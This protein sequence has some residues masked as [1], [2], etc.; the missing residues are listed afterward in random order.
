MAT[1]RLETMLG[2][3]AVAVHPEDPR[4]QHLLGRR[5]QH[6]FASRTIPIIADNVRE[7]ERREG[8]RGRGGRGGEGGG[9]V[10][11][12]IYNCFSV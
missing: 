1:T 6:P 9:C 7:R 4:Y 5:V 10:M 3:T 8:V 12:Y 2:D 11:G